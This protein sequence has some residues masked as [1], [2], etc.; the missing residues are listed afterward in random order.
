VLVR[1]LRTALA[2]PDVVRVVLVVRPEDEQLVAAAV[3]PHLGER[4]VLLVH[5]GATRHASELAALAALE[6]DLLSGDVDVVALHDA[7]R[8]LARPELFTRALEAAEAQG[9]AVP[10]VELPALV[11]RD[12]GPVA[13]LTGDARTVGVQT[14]QAFRGPDLLAAYR[15]ADASGVEATDTAG[16]V[17]AWA[18]ATGTDLAVVAVPSSPAN[19]KVTYAEDVPAAIALLDARTPGLTGW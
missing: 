15:W 18:A 5:G 19:L 16:C 6:Q 8:P 14:P 11:R 2:V 13:D 7:A 9:G 12:G 3:A 4:E 10:A 17:S 1:A